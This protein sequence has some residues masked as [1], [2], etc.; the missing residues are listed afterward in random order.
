MLAS[1][2]TKLLVP[3]LILATVALPALAQ[4]LAA[5]AP[6]NVKI[7]YEDARVRVVRLRIAPHETLPMHNRPARVVIALTANDVRLTSPDGKTRTVQVPAG[8]IAWSGPGQRSVTNLDAPL[9]NVIVELKN[10]TGPA[11]AVTHPPSPDDPRAL[12]EP[13]HRWLFENQYVRVYDVHIPPGEIA[14]YHRHAYDTVIVQISGGLT[15][16]Q[17]QGGEW[18]KPE[19]NAP[20]TVEFTADANKPR[21]HRVRNDGNQ[22]FHVVLVQLMK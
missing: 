2:M 17:K 7:E 22:D 1:L 20:G 8:N 9:E 11:K 15:S 10:V 18:G 14:E 6:K 19:T 3:M 12:I 21:T 16:E 5:V 13:H 4:D